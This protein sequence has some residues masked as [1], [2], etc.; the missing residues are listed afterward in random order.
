MKLAERVYALAKK[1][2][3]EERYGLIGQMQR[4]SVSIPSNIAEGS[5]RGGNKEYVQF[6]RVSRGSS[7]ELETQLLLS[8][9]VYNIDS[10]EEMALLKEVQ[11]MLESLLKKLLKTD[12]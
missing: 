6:L 3:V 10:S 9:S 8:E 11:K 2:P 1:M 12:N 5:K 4:S 7:A